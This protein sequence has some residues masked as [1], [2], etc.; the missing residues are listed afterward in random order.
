MFLTLNFKIYI[1]S[2]VCFLICE[3]NTL[4]SFFSEM[5]SP[6]DDQPSARRPA[7]PSLRDDQ[8]SLRDDQPSARRP[9]KP[10]LRDDQPSLRDDQPSQR[11]D[12]PSQACVMTSQA[13]ET[14]NPV[15]AAKRVEQH[16]L[17]CHCLVH[18]YICLLHSICK[19]IYCLR[20][21]C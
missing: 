15:D 19:F 20:Y 11:D 21:I 7:K 18:I 13:C 6:S 3:L 4:C 16:V 10:S 9:A 17:H 1:L 5:I 12:Q 2:S 8:P 14:T